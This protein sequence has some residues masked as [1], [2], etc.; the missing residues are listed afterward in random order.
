MLSQ[1]VLTSR[2]CCLRLQE[3]PRPPRFAPF[4][5]SLPAP[6]T[7][8]V[9]AS[10]TPLPAHTQD[11]VLPGLLD[12]GQV[13]LSPTNFHQLSQRNP[14]RSER[15]WRAVECRSKAHPMPRSLVA[16]APSKDTAGGSSG[17]RCQATFR[18]EASAML[19]S[20]T[21]CRLTPFLPTPSVRGRHVLTQAC[22]P[23]PQRCF[24]EHGRIWRA[25]SH[26]N[27]GQVRFFVKFRKTA[28]V[29]GFC[30]LTLTDRRPAP[31]NTPGSPSC[32]PSP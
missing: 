20:V 14:E 23:R 12:F 25:Q 32:T 5:G 15:S 8:P 26:E 4:R 22:G 17:K 11:S 24:Q 10:S 2:T 19:G 1:V 13:G 16:L 27:R 7:A 29:P 9:Y 21:E 6:H 31:G 18:Q 28:P 3:Q 30:P